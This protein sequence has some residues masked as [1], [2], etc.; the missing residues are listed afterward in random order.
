MTVGNACVN[1]IPPAREQNS[2]SPRHA[3]PE[4]VNRMLSLRLHVQRR[5][6]NR[7]ACELHDTCFQGLAS[8]LFLLHTATEQMN[9]DSP[10]K[11]EVSRALRII[12]EALKEARATWQGL[13]SSTPA[14]TSLEH[15]LASLRDE[16]VMGSDIGFRIF[17]LGQPKQLQPA[18]QKQIYLIGRE[19]VI[20]AFRHSR[21]TR[22]ETEIEYLRRRTRLLV[23]DNG[24]G[25]DAQ[26]LRAGRDSYWGLVGM[27]ERAEAI[28]ASLRIWSKLGIGTEV[29]VSVRGSRAE[30]L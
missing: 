7:I 21:A 24:C 2:N 11:P 4:N 1:R 14:P 10:G 22:V 26:T 15:A 30:R 23:R 19:A 18:I 17:V 12:R 3:G 16:Y 13:Q 8:G 25:I 28:G 9:P 20:N 5:E 29:E 6:R 27:R